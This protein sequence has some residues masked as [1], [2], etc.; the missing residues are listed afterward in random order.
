MV[1]LDNDDLVDVYVVDILVVG[2]G[3]CDFD[4]VYL[5]VVDGY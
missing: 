1:L 3:L 5:I 2:V 4:V